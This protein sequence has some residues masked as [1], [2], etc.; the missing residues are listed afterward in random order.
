MNNKIVAQIRQCLHESEAYELYNVAIHVYCV[1]PALGPVTN[2]IV[3]QIRQCLHES[4]AY[5][6]YILV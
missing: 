3:A 4:E 6:L 2:K 1:Q 5:K